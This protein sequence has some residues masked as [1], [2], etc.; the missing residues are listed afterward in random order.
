MNSDM[1]EISEIKNIANLDSDWTIY[2]QTYL[3]LNTKRKW[4]PMI[5][6]FCENWILF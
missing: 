4:I 6:A 5:E 3:T 2:F 1:A